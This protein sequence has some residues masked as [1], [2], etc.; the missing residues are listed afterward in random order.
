MQLLSSVQGNAYYE[1]AVSPV[2][3]NSPLFTASACVVSAGYS[4][5]STDGILSCFDSGA[6]K[7]WRIGY[8]SNGSGGNA[9]LVATLGDG[10]GTLGLTLALPQFMGR[11][12]LVSLVVDNVGA[13]LYVNGQLGVIQSFITGYSGTATQRLS[14]GAVNSGFGDP[15]GLKVFGVAFD[16]T[17]FSAFGAGQ[18][19][20]ALSQ[21]EQM[22]SDVNF[23]GVVTEY[24]FAWDVP[25][26]LQNPGTPIASAIWTARAGGENLNFAGGG[27]QAALI[28]YPHPVW[29]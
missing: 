4:A 17:S 23:A 1:S 19:F 8:T 15:D 9:S 27:S 20:E 5:G 13:A 24:A 12:F 18:A 6:S 11:M 26:G 28:N 21:A 7:G 16:P 22:A 3:G 2:F 25:T 14:L 29:A 10:A